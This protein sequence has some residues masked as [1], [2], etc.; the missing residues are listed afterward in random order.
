MAIVSF[1]EDELPPLSEEDKARLRA[2]AE[3]PDSEIDYSDIPKM[4]E[5]DWARM[6]RVSDFPTPRRPGSRPCGSTNSRS[7]DRR[8]PS[9]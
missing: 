1:W 9:D 2:L 7:R 4:T 5:D 3:R 8:S 6:V